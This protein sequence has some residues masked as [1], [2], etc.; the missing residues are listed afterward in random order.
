L[1]FELTVL[2]GSR[3]DKDQRRGPLPLK[4]EI[5]AGPM[6]ALSTRRLCF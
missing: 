3:S 6:K 1:E 2:R 5:G 4:I